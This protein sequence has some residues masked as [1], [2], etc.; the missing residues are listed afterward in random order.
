MRIT[1]SYVDEKLEAYQ[2]AIDALLYHEPGSDGDK[3]LASHLRTKLAKKLSSEA[4][5][6]YADY[7]TKRDARDKGTSGIDKLAQILSKIDG[8]IVTVVHDQIN[9]TGSGEVIKEAE[10]IMTAW[11]ALD[12]LKSKVKA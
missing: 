1:E 9:I 11:H 5:R 2:V 12:V 6:W 8:A 7:R 4:D 3:K 10:Q